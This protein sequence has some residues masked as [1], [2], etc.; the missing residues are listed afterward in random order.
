MVTWSSALSC[1]DGSRPL[2][3]LYSVS[4]A[5]QSVCGS[6]PPGAVFL[7]SP[8][9]RQVNPPQ[10]GLC[11][12]WLLLCQSCGHKGKLVRVC[13]CGRETWW[14]WKWS[15]PGECGTAAVGLGLSSWYETRILTAGQHSESGSVI[16]WPHLAEKPGGHPLL[17]LRYLWELCW[18]WASIAGKTDTVLSSRV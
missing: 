1:S 18:V 15:E 17:P 3:C 16:A 11:A 5:A 7:A 13:Q 12:V 2:C 10:P 14:P 6:S 8:L 9:L 4:E